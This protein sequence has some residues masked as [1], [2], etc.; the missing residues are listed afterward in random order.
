MAMPDAAVYEDFLAFAHALADRAREITL[1]YFRR[2][3][4]VDAKADNSPVTIADR[5]T[6][7]S[8][9]EAI[10][11]R[12]PEHGIIGEEHADKS[13]ESCYE[14]VLDPIDG[15]RNFISGYPLYGT[16]VALL[17]NGVPVVSVIDI[18]AQDERFF[19][20]IDRQSSYRKGQ[21]ER[22][23]NTA[24]NTELAAAV[25]F[26]TDYAMFTAAENQRARALREAV[27]MLRYNGDCYLYAMLAA[28]WIDVVLE[29]DLKPYDFLPLT[30]IV[31]QAGGKISDWQGRALT[32]YSNGQVLA[33]AN[34]DLHRQALAHLQ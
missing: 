23:I 20:S 8:L 17:E 34:A 15:T 13:A 21:I 31:E 24:E 28:G 33:S 7:Q 10:A 5:L 4:A 16:L 30:L 2:R 18:P 1:S 9:R 27:N 14:W 26:S 6:E 22:R 11:A 12:F 25:M 32:K 29:A 19:A 3:V